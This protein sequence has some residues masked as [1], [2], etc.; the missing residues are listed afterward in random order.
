MRS[1]FLGRGG[2]GVYIKF[3][4]FKEIFFVNLHDLILFRREE[5][6]AHIEKWNR[7][8]ASYE[9]LRVQKEKLIGDDDSLEKSSKLLKAKFDAN[10][11]RKVELSAKS[12]ELEKM[13]ATIR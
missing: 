2:G 3:L 10:L 5:D 6:N 9:Q 8:T 1:F 13:A 12:R 4:S 7:L 11:G